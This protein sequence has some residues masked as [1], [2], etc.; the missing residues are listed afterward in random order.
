LLAV[1]G[2]LG[3]AL[4]VTAVQTVGSFLPHRMVEQDFSHLYLGGRLWRDGVQPYGVSLIEYNQAIGS[5][6]ADTMPMVTHPPLLVWL[7]GLLAT[8][9]VPVAFPIYVGIEFVSLMIVA[10]LCWRLI[11][12]RLSAEA[13][14]LALGLWM[15]SAPMLLQFR[16]SQ[17]QLPLL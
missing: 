9:S 15:F 11:G 3:I 7:F 17:V 4:V 16:L 6:F 14:F 2:G 12:R 1:K 13:W 10:L 5:P 8:F